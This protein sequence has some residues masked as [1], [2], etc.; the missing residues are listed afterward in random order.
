MTCA[1]EREVM[2]SVLAG[3]SLLTAECGS[4]HSRY[5]VAD[6]GLFTGWL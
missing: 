4:A 1:L 2:N 6:T 5:A 3:C